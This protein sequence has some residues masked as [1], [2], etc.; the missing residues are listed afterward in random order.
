[1][2]SIV[3]RFSKKTQSAGKEE[4][5]KERKGEKEKTEGDRRR[6]KGGEG[7]KRKESKRGVNVSQGV[8]WPHPSVQTQL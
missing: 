2:R 5:R 4:E 6:E 7:K 3:D 1:M 8:A